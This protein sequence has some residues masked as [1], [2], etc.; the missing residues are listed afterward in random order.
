MI[1]Y[2]LAMT[3]PPPSCVSLSSADHSFETPMAQAASCLILL[4]ASRLLPLFQPLQ[5]LGEIKQLA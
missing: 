5:E 1:H 2:K 3:E 4:I